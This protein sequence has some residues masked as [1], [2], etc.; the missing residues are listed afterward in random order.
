MSK[1][2][3]WSIRGIPMTPVEKILGIF[4]IVLELNKLKLKNLWEKSLLHGP[5]TE[6]DIHHIST[7]YIT[8][9]N[10]NGV[11]CSTVIERVE[12]C[13]LRLFRYSLVSEKQFWKMYIDPR[14]IVLLSNNFLDRFALSSQCDLLFCQRASENVIKPQRPVPQERRG[15]INNQIVILEN[16]LT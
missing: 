15:P 10:G 9:S 14:H 3:E 7:L 5:G 16:E 12:E 4:D 2:L 11:I 8:F 6:K 1:A 13:F